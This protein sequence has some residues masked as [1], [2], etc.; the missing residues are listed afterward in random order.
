MMKGRAELFGKA[1]LAKAVAEQPKEAAEYACYLAYT[2]LTATPVILEKLQE[3]DMIRLFWDMEMPLVY[4]L[5]DMQ[6][7][8]IRVNA[9]ELR[10]TARSFMCASWSW[11]KRSMRTPGRNLTS[12]PRSSSASF[13]FLKIKAPGRKENQERIFHGGGRAGEAG[14]QSPDRSEDSEIPAACEIKIDLCGRTGKLYS[15]GMAGSMEPSTR[16]S[17]RPVASAAP[18][19]N[20]QIYSGAHGAWAAPS[21]GVYR[22]RGRCF[23]RRRLFTDRAARACGDGG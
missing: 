23:D 2:A 9:Q 13:C 7:V 12:I 1:P 22:A 10:H 18:I 14:A 6:E 17:R 3:F 8:G 4:T 16:R 19:L 20:L 15:G 11:K 5:Y 21:Q